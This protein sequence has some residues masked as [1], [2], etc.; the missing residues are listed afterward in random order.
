MIGIPATASTINDT[1]RKI[2]LYLIVDFIVTYPGPK[3]NG[4]GTA[5]DG[6]NVASAAANA[7]T[8][9]STRDARV[10]T[11]KFSVEIVD[12]VVVKVSSTADHLTFIIFFG[13]LFKICCSVF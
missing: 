8:I 7:I 11:I 13:K 5:A 12:D 3:N 6:V 9:P 1:I 4:E 2:M 10:H